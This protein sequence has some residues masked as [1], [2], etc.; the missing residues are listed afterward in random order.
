MNYF[1]AV[2]VFVMLLFVSAMVGAIVHEATHIILNDG[3]FERICILDCPP[4]EGMGFFGNHYTPVGVYLTE[5]INSLAK[6]EN[7][8][9]ATG[10]IA[11]ALT[12]FA[13]I[14]LNTKTRSVQNG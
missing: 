1:L 10:T 11:F 3:R 13:L 6:D 4:K 2:L 12:L 5:P 8:A 7:I 9:G 14:I